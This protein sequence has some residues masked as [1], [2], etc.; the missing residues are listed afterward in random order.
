MAW[1]RVY[2]PKSAGQRETAQTRRFCGGSPTGPGRNRIPAMRTRNGCRG[3]TLI[4]LCFGLA[5]VAVARRPGCARLSV[6]PA[7]RRGSLRHL[8]AAGRPAADAR[9]R[10]SSKS[11][12]VDLCPSDAAGN[13]LAAGAPAP[14][15]RASLETGGAR[16]AQHAAMRCPPGVVVRAS[17]SPLR[18]WPDALRR[19][20]RHPNYLRRAGRRPATRHRAEPERPRTPAKPRRPRRA[21]DRARRAASR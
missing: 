20:H 16:V 4:E 18:F 3:V 11:R 6:E 8:R 15:W 12:P 14:Y 2:A 9:Q 13:C 1:A 7:G 21:H 17:R 10:P 5:I 19:K